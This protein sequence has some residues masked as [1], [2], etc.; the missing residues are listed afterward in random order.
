MVMKV[1]GHSDVRTA[2]RY[3]YPILDPIRDAIDQRNYSQFTSQ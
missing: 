2:M 1:V 3:Q